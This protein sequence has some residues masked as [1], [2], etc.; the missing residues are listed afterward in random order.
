M[1]LRDHTRQHTLFL[2]RK[3]CYGTRKTCKEDLVC[4][5]V[6]AYQAGAVMYLVVLQSLDQNC[7][8]IHPPEIQVYCHRLRYLFQILAPDAFP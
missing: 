8:V 5:V 2:C 7:R 3:E 6:V 4:H 1:R